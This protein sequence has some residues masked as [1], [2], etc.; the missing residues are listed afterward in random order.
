[1][2]EFQASKLQINRLA[3]AVVD[4]ALALAGGSG[5]AG[6][7]PLARLVRDVRAGQFMQPFSPHEALGFLGSV[8]AGIDPDPLA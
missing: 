7:D 4:R 8:A 2:A 1:M 6:T 5:Y 3:V